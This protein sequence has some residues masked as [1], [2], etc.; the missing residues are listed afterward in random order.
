MRMYALNS[1]GRL[2]AHFRDCVFELELQQAA[3]V[4]GGGDGGT[5]IHGAIQRLRGPTLLQA[6][7]HR[8]KGEK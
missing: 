7:P 3:A 2:H 5:G 8:Q 6:L 4:R 1:R